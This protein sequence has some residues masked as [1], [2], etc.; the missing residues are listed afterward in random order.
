M[1]NHT[2]GFRR[3]R[4][5]LLA[6]LT[7]MGEAP[8]S[9]LAAADQEAGPSGTAGLAV[10]SEP[11][12]A[13]V[14]INGIAVGVTPLRLERVRAGRHSVLLLMPGHLAQKRDVEISVGLTTSLRTRLTSVSQLVGP[15]AVRAQVTVPEGEK[16]NGGKLKYIVPGAILAVGGGLATYKLATRN[17]LPV[18]VGAISPAATG[19]ARL[20]N[21]VFDGSGSH[22]PNKDNLTYVWDFGDGTTGSGERTT[23]R[24]DRPGAFV[25]RLTVSDGKLS[26]TVDVGSVNVINNLEGTWVGR[27]S[28][29]TNTHT[30][31]IGSQG[32]AP[33]AGTWTV[34]AFSGRGAMSGTLDGSNNYVCPCTVTISGNESS[35]PLSMD[36][37]GTL[38][39]DGRSLS[40]GGSVTYGA[41]STIRGRFAGSWILSR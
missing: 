6:L 27:H 3:P 26:S 21:Y 28:S 41:C 32:A 36:F 24:F 20:T 33:F 9:L 29:F 39:A 18:A 37:T 12:G 5:C 11:S 22:D 34:S 16:K 23:K 25:V 30:L 15:E 19:L 7:M 4:S 38:S 40:G 2:H 17:E 35:C 14:Y 13:S 31:I 1:L 8:C 10:A